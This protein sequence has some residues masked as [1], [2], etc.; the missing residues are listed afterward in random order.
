MF[1]TRNVL[2]LWFKTK[3]LKR[4]TLFQNTLYY[5]YTYIHISNSSLEHLSS[6]NDPGIIFDSELIFSC[7][8]ELIKNKVSVFLVLLNAHVKIFMIVLL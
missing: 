1:K 6:F 8:T 3:Y 5:I 7:H 2:F 4:R